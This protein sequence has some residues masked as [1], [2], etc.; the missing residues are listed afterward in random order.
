MKNQS[1][2]NRAGA[3][4]AALIFSIVASAPSARAAVIVGGNYTS[5]ITS[6][7]TTLG[8][9]YTTDSGMFA[10]PVGLGAGDTIF[11]SNDGGSD[12]GLDY[13]AFLNAGGHLIAVGGSN[14]QP[15]RDWVAGYFNLTDIASGWHQSNAWHTDAVVPGTQFLPAD[16]AF[17][18]SNMSYHMLAF[19]ATTNTTLLG[20]NDEPNSIA[21][22]RTYSNGGY[23]Y[24]MA[25]DIGGDYT[26]PGDQ[27][28]FVVPFVQS[29]LNAGD[30]PAVPEPATVTLLGSALAGLFVLARKR[31]A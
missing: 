5:N 13:N 12:A 21:A 27:T 17:L 7:L 6:A 9:G 26:T 3:V 4:L 16:Y 8:I 19:L 24:Y 29:A 2:T 25:L 23:F 30:A 1:F 31:R 10:S 20:H 15:Y 28:D 22:I 11:M 18:D 14:Y